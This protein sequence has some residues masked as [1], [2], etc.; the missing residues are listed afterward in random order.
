[1]PR[2]EA[3]FYWVYLPE[4][5]EAGVVVQ[6]FDFDEAFREGCELLNPDAGVEVQIHELGESREFLVPNH[7]FLDTDDCDEF[8]A[9]HADDC[10]GFCDHIG[11]RN[12]CMS[13]DEFEAL[14]A[15]HEAERKA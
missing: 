13:E 5:D 11:H 6:A 14:K 7:P 12:M 2:P 10:D 8:C 4:I 15:E 1:M 3:T 9:P